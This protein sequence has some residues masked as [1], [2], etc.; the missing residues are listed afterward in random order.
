MKKRLFA[1]ALLAA[2]LA[3]CGDSGKKIEIDELNPENEAYNLSYEYATRVI[4]ADNYEEFR[5]ARAALEAHEDAF[6]A[7]IGGDAYLIFLEECNY[8]LND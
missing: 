4:S 3:S 7:D 8:I 6:R 5:T 2:T 1:I